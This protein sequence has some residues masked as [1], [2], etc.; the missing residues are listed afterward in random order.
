VKEFCAGGG[1]AI[2]NKG[3]AGCV[4]TSVADVGAVVYWNGGWSVFWSCSFGTLKSKVGAV[5][6]RTTA[7]VAAPATDIEVEPGLSRTLVSLAGASDAPKVH[8]EG[9]DGTRFDVPGPEGDYFQNTRR[10]V[11]R[12]PEK[13]TTDIVLV[14]PAAG[15]WRITPLPG[16]TRIVSIRQ[17]NPLPTRIVTGALI[18]S[19]H[20]RTLR[21]T[22]RLEKGQ[23]VSFVERAPGIERVVGRATA[24]KGELRFTIA[25]GPAGP[26][27]IDAV[28]ESGGIAVRAET[29]ARLRAPGPLVL[30]APR[31]VAARTARGLSVRWD[32]VNGAAAY[33]AR[34]A[35]SD[36]RI[37]TTLL[38]PARRSLT[39]TLDARTFGVVT[40]SALSSAYRSG[41]P[42]R[43]R[44]AAIPSL[45]V[46]P[47]VALAELRRTRELR[48][49]CNAA[50]DGTC[51]VTANVRGRVIASGS[52]NVSF[53]R[54][55]TLRIRFTAA[56]LAQ[57]RP[58]D[59]IVVSAAI[60]G[61][62]VRVARVRVR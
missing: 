38:K 46:V 57:L 61:E 14:R 25:D 60:P 1:V 51:S 15:T 17:A 29:V 58:G 13:R 19:G 9:P 37:A 22:T 31:L 52:T 21:F 30:P 26:R 7:G 35:L 36:G 4:A 24:P 16:S 42:A 54:P 32:A 33:R 18:G 3:V 20:A 6:A 40:V 44:V 27:R 62:G 8:V 55:K 47:R 41:R 50:G 28:I 5:Y 34:I 45:S 48:V 56:G 59:A 23:R 49:T 12:L 43:V 10:L 11:L 53:A 39:V 2:S